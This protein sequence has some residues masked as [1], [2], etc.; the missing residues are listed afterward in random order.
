MSFFSLTEVIGSGAFATVYKGV[1][2]RHH[3][4]TDQLMEEEIAVKKMKSEVSV[5][6]RVKFLQEAAMMAQFRH[7]NIVAIRGIVIEEPVRQ[8]VCGEQG[9]LNFPNTLKDLLETT[10]QQTT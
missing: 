4:E 6:E 2:S 7:T 5:E 9:M 8:N 1:W 3:I 10:V